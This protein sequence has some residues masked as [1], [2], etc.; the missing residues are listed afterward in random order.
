MS[1]VQL[2]GSFMLLKPSHQAFMLLVLFF[3]EPSKKHKK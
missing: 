3:S 1:F 2:I